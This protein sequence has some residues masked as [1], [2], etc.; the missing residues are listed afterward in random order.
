MLNLEGVPVCET[1]SEPMA[2]MRRIS[3]LRY[4]GL[5]IACWCVSMD[6]F[7]RFRR[8]VRVVCS[9]NRQDGMR[10]LHS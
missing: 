6:A 1:T 8:D 5:L 2:N 10:N 3:Y 9:G 7:V 4:G